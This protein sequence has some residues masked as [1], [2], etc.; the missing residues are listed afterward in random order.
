[1]DNKLLDKVESFIFQF[2]KWLDDYGETSYDHQSFFAGK[3]G[4]RAKTLYY[5]NWIQ[6]LAYNLVDLTA[7]FFLATWML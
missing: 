6:K 4:G 7:L 1:M 3:L 5:K 2:I